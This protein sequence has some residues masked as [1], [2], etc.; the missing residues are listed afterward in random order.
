M[1]I[2]RGIFEQGYHGLGFEMPMLKKKMR[3]ERGE[4][5]VGQP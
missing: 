2:K 4:I 1:L 5:L 3:R